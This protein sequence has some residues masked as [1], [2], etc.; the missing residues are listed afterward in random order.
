MAEN[1]KDL[2]EIKQIIEYPKL[3]LINYFENLKS[4]VDLDFEQR[5][6]LIKDDE[7]K[8]EKTDKWLKLIEIIEKCLKKCLNNHIPKEL[9]E[10]T[11][12]L[13]IQLSEINKIQLI[14]N[15]LE[16][17]LLAND[18]YLVISMNS[19]TLKYYTKKDTGVTLFTDKEY[20]LKF[21]FLFYLNQ[22]FYFLSSFEKILIIEEGFNQVE[23]FH[24]IEK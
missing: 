4:K 8:R 23:I 1:S 11:N 5:L 14:R 7:I 19:G 13:I 9:I 21:Y 2:E 10:E 15:K 22:K 17:Y 20:T 12:G 18:S 3:Y 6:S 16:S 24:L